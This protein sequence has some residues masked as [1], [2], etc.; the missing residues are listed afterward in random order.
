MSDRLVTVPFLALVFAH[1]TQALGY[2]SMLLL[3]LYV[4]SLGGTRA[5]IGWIMSATAISGVLCRPAVGWALDSVGRRPTLWVGTALLSAGMMLFG[6]VDRVGPLVYVSRL[7]LGVGMGA[8]FTGYFTLAADLVPESRRTEGLALFGISGLAP[9]ALNPVWQRAGVEPEDLRWLYPAF[10]ALILLSSAALR[11]VPEPDRSAH[12]EADPVPV[13]RALTHPR[14]LPV[15]LSTVVFAGLVAIYFAYA[16]VT[17]AA[18]GV[19]DSAA[20][21]FTYAAGAVTVRAFGA[22]LPD[23][24]GPTNL[25]APALASYAAAYLVAA[26]AWTTQ[27]FLLAGLLAGVGH[28]YC[29]PVITSQVV[30]RAPARLRGTA[31]AAFTALWEVAGLALTPVFGYVADHWD[32]ATMFALATLFGLLGLAAWALWEHLSA[33]A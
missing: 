14:L 7:V 15:W 19:P 29:F 33:R 17:A 2:S 28:G 11:W 21:W 5:E 3:P 9:L 1:F 24:I 32:D 12:R 13:W 27:A 30:T 25:V 22:R 26:G 16:T 23:R 4:E 6:L 18:R 8:L 20:I 10:G 31:L